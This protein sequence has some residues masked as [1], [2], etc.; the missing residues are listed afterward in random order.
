MLLLLLPG[1]LKLVL[2]QCRNSSTPWGNCYTRKQE[3]LCS[4]HRSAHVP[5]PSPKKSWH[6]EP[7][8]NSSVY[9]PCRSQVTQTPFPPAVPASYASHNMFVIRLFPFP[10]TAQFVGYVTMNKLDV[11]EKLH[12][13]L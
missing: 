11:F 10:V 3:S 8:E 1:T 12:P 7:V 9:K 4:Q 5:I 2:L 6:T 13:L